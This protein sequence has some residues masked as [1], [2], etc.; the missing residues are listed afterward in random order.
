MTDPRSLLLARAFVSAHAPALEPYL[1][2][3]AR[4]KLLAEWANDQ[5][6]VQTRAASVAAKS[7]LLWLIGRGVRLFSASPTTVSADGREV[8][9]AADAVLGLSAVHP[10]LDGAAR[11]LTGCAQELREIATAMGEAAGDDQLGPLVVELVPQEDRRKLAQFWT[12]EPISEFMARWAIQ[13]P[14]DRVLEP[15]AGGGR[16]VLEA[17]AALVAQGSS[18]TAIPS[19]IGANEIDPVVRELLLANLEAGGVRGW[20]DV[21]ITDFLITRSPAQGPW[22]AV[23]CNPPYTRHHLL[24]PTYKTTLQNLAAKENGIHLSGFA[25]LFVPFWLHGMGLLWDGGRAA[26]ITP[27]ELF[28]AGYAEPVARWALEHANLRAC[29]TFAENILAFDGVDTAGLISLAEAGA[30]DGR[31]V[32]F[33]E[34]TRWPGCEALLASLDG[35]VTTPDWGVIVDRERVDL[36]EHHKWFRDE[37]QIRTGWTRL[38]DLVRV[39]RGIATG[40]NDFFTLTDDER[41]TAGLD[42]TSLVP[43]ACKARDLPGLTLDADRHAAL[44]ADGRKAWLFLPSRDQTAWTDEIRAYVARGEQLGVPDGS[45]VSKRSNWWDGERRPV[46]ELVYTY[47]SRGNPRFA[48][49]RVGAQVLNSY[50]HVYPSDELRALGDDALA[51]LAAILNAPTVLAGLRSVGR[52]YGGGTVKVEP[53]ELDALLIPDLRKLS[54]DDLSVLASAF[55]YA[56]VDLNNAP[57]VLDAALVAVGVLGSDEAIAI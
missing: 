18:P 45:L 24:P 34:L 14:L 26:Y 31:P 38:A 4:A 33:I 39:M 23:I 10:I 16:L 52:T 20:S 11:T 19:L 30:P 28:E 51:A 46:P 35:P 6:V 27:G 22:D 48:R 32:R 49:N 8:L 7:S 21:N 42:E 37:Q 56:E 15:A 1:A 36:V 3:P 41:A 5:G 55:R 50:L 12:P 40:N 25:S 57:A 13:S 47:M 43:V 29:I 17:A 44:R 54:V 53:R 2:D 9:S